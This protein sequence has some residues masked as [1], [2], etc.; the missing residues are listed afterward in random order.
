MAGFRHGRLQANR[1]CD[2]EDLK[3]LLAHAKSAGQAE[4][5]VCRCLREPTR[6][7]ILELS[8]FGNKPYQPTCDGATEGRVEAILR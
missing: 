5:R 3:S 1:Q 8:D 2:P 6:R 4:V 7:R